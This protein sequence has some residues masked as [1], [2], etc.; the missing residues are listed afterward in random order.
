MCSCSHRIGFCMYIK[1]LC[2]DHFGSILHFDQSLPSG[3]AILKSKDPD[4][5]ECRIKGYFFTRLRNSRDYIVAGNALQNCLRSWERF[6]GDV[7]GVLKF[8]N[9]VAAI[10]VD[11]DVIIQA[12]T[13]RNGDMNAD[14]SLFSAF[15]I[16]KERNGLTQEGGHERRNGR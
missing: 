8:G 2:I 7:Y 13:Y 12:Y 14:P 1:W 9:Y 5:L 4:A 15:C 6:D 10:E 11:E 16:W 3:L